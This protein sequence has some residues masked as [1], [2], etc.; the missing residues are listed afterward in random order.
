M[1]S[2]GLAFKLCHNSYDTSGLPTNHLHAPYKSIQ[3]SLMFAE[4]FHEKLILGNCVG[5]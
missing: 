3:P 4:G 2:V 5:L 1:S